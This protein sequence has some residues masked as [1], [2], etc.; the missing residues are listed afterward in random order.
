MEAANVHGRPVFRRENGVLLTSF[1]FGGEEISIAGDKA[2]IVYTGHVVKDDRFEHIL[3]NQILQ[4]GIP[5]L[6][7]SYD[8]L[9]L[10]NSP[11]AE[12]MGVSWDATYI[13]YCVENAFFLWETLQERDFG[14]RPNIITYD[15][16]NSFMYYTILNYIQKLRN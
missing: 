4:L 8:N 5:M 7:G 6:E 13:G 10:Y 2:T 11:T 3:N 9:L 16:V 15:S 14:E 1:G 12:S